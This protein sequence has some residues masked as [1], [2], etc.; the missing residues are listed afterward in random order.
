MISFFTSALCF[1][2]KG[3]YIHLERFNKRP[4]LIHTGISFTDEAKTV[5]YDF[6]SRPFHNGT[7]YLDA[8]SESDSIPIVD[9]THGHIP[10]N[11]SLCPPYSR[12]I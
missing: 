4:S 12:L 7:Y 9:A 6:R 5:R 8:P 2:S 3:V 10:S 1:S 11:M